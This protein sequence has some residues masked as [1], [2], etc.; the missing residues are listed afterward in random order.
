MAIDRVIIVGEAPDKQHV[1]VLSV[2]GMNKD[3]AFVRSLSAG[4]KAA[5]VSWDIV[6]T[7]IFVAG[8]VL[9][10]LWHWWAFVPATVVMAVLHKANIKSLT[11]FNL[12]TV[13]KSPGAMERLTQRGLVWSAPA[14][15][16]VPEA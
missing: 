8:V 1:T 12:E 16:V 15:S 10:I 11:E 2:D 14:K 7:L 5:T 3:P 6:G 9:S 4:Q 13:A